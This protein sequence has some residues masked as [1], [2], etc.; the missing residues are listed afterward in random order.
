M[1][2][3][4]PE[5]RET[6]QRR[7]TVM[8]ADITGFTSLVEQA[9]D[10]KA[11]VIIR[12]CMSIL[13]G[14]ARRYGA[15]VDHHQGDAIMAVFG[16]PKAVEDAPRA[17]VNAA[18]EMRREVTRF[19][20][21]QLL[22]RPLDVHIGIETGPVISGETTGSVIREFHVVGDAVNSQ[23]ASRTKH[24]PANSGSAGRPGAPRAT[25][26]TSSRWARSK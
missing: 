24:Q 12:E 5:P 23:R 14:I 20:Q 7:A 9:G 18:I 22:E 19:N 3:Q 6:E 4:H 26:S 13:D 25:S 17:A 10:A 16:V 1:D 11:Y 2:P 15:S 8:F 21:G